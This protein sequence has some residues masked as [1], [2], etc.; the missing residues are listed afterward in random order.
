MNHLFTLRDSRGIQLFLP[1]FSVLKD[2]VNSSPTTNPPD[3]L[4]WRSKSEDDSSSS[5]N[6][7]YVNGHNDHKHRSNSYD[8]AGQCNQQ[9]LHT[10]TAE[11]D[12]R[13]SNPHSLA[14]GSTIL[15]GNPSRSGVIKWMGYLR[16]VNTYFAGIEMV[17]MYIAM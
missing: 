5:V 6:S 17:C 1:I 9:S 16:G 13:I 8:S 14:V 4:R 10:L 11:Y 15:C 7:S 3:R 12:K 2:E